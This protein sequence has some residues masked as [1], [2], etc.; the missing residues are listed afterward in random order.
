MVKL[1]NFAILASGLAVTAFSLEKSASTRFSP[2]SQISTLNQVSSSAPVH[3]S[4]T[5]LKSAD[6]EIV[7][8]SKAPAP[9]AKKGLL[10]AVWN[11]NTKLTIYLAVWYLGNIYCK[12]FIQNFTID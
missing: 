4:P 9:V 5:F 7:G 11:E 1:I 10:D 3:S 6:A 8:A 2:K 12:L